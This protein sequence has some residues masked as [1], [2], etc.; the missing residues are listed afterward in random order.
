MEELLNFFGL[1]KL[2]RKDLKKEYKELSKKYHPDIKE[3]G[4][5]EMFIKINYKYN[6][7]LKNTI[8][9]TY[10]IKLTL[11]DLLSKKEF[12]IEG[13]SFKFELKDYFNNRNRVVKINDSLYKIKLDVILDKNV[14]LKKNKIIKTKYISFLD[15]RDGFVLDFLNNIPYAVYIPMKDSLNKIIKTE[16]N[17]QK[18]T[19]MYKFIIKV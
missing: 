19:I 4:D 1:K 5:A 18:I 17:G 15:I 16:I 6:E 2:L 8:R 3:T 10:I 9:K 11:D 7:L 12:I 13:K 14:E